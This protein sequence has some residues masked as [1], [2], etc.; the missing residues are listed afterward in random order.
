MTLAPAAIAWFQFALCAAL[1]AVAGTRLSRYGDVIA[2]KTGLGATWVGLLLMATVTSLPELVTGISAVALARAPD[3]AVG[4]ALGACVINLAMLVVL[5]LLDRGGSVYTRAS[6]GHI[7]SA[8]FGVVLAG[9]VGI[10]L[11]F[12]QHGWTYALGWV[13]VY[14]LFIALVYAIAMRT[15]FQ[16]ERRSRAAFVE[17]K[18]ERY[19]HIT[20]RAAGV[21][22]AA[23]A[24]V[25]VGAG[26]WLPHIGARLATA[27]SWEQSF[28]GSLFIALATTL[29]EMTVTVAALRLGALDLAVSNLLGS[30][31]FNLLIV[32]IDDVFYRP[33][34]LLSDVSG[35][36]AVSAFSAVMMSGVV[37]VGLLYRPSGRVFK[38]VGWA[39]LV[40]LTLYLLNVSFLYLYSG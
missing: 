20:L 9:F 23:A 28:V 8:G 13:G 7:L 6:Q 39:S 18:V 3:I 24:L 26:I 15:L 17:E 4:N 19:P 16:Y 25:V 33:G 38:T 37:I 1:I 32:A 2:D 35:A 36:H 11:L 12:A 40:L 14:S 27:M 30:N 10:N 29:P 31:L 21:R 22:Y 34:P 5:D